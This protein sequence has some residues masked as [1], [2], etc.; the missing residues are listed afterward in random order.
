MKGEERKGNIF[1]LVFKKG[2]TITDQCSA[3][4]VLAYAVLKNWV[5]R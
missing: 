3:L 1:K 4:S 2:L 5:C